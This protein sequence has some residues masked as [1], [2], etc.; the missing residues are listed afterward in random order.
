[1]TTL[2][3]AKLQAGGRRGEQGFTLVEVLISMFVLTVGL[4]SLL[5]VF[6]MAMA[7]TQTTQQD[8]IA[9][10]IAQEAYE[11]VFTARETANIQWQQIQ[12]SGTGQVPDGIFVGG[13]KSIKQPGTDGIMGTADDSLAADQ[14]LTLP[15]PDGMIGFNSV[16]GKNDDITLALTNFQRSIV[17]T[18]VVTAGST[19]ADLRTITINVQY[20]TPQSKF[21]KTYALSGFIS[22]YR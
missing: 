21:P 10:Q 17:I 11:A 2:R 4:V 22:Q 7:K 16:T 9:K 1:M 19:V 13:L 6:A 12:N 3:E 14:T 15:G 8:M 5:G 18:P 20:Y